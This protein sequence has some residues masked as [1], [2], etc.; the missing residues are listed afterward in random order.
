M[1]ALSIKQ[2][3]A[4]LIIAGIKTVE[5]RTWGTLYRGTLVIVSTQKPDRA[6]TESM[7]AKLGTLPAAC[8]IN[9]AILGTV[10]LTG[11]ILYLEEEDEIGTDHPGLTES[12]YEWWDDY[13]TGWV[14]E[15]PRL[16]SSPI[17][18]KGRLGLYPLPAGVME[19]IQKRLRK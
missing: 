13:C 3:W 8:E 4:G 16:L 7:R 17:P 1:R 19:E 11:H 18:Y 2:P 5:N 10:E 6:A 15:S 14:L 9:G 12:N